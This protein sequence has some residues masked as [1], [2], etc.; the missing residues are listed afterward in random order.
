MTKNMDQAN[1]GCRRRDFLKLGAAGG[2]S[3]AL[4]NAA[5]A[6]PRTA[7]ARA[8]PADRTSCASALSA[9]AARGN[10]ILNELLKLEGLEILGILRHRGEQGCRRAGQ[11]GE[12]GQAQAPAY[13][14][15][16]TDFQ[17]LC[18]REDLDLVYT[19][20]PWE[21]HVP[22]CLAAMNNG[23]HAVPEVPA[24]V[25]LDECWAAGGNGGGPASTA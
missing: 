12:G 25:T 24:A 1:E 15:G 11:G 22:V 18:E 20:T 23:K 2:L 4:G 8:G 17:R 9:W 10:S 5:L 21:W 3:I 14:R 13:T 16:N 7:V 6:E 19:P